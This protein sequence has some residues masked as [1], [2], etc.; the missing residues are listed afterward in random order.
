MEGET[1]QAALSSRQHPRLQI[2]ERDG[3]DLAV[4]FRDLDDAALLD[5]EQSPRSVT[6]IRQQYGIDEPRHR[7]QKPH[8]DPGEVRGTSPRARCEGA[9]G[10]SE[11]GGSRGADASEHE[12][13]DRRERHSKTMGDPIHRP[14][15]ALRAT[16]GGA[17]V[18]APAPAIRPDVLKPAPRHRPS[19]PMAAVAPCPVSAPCSSK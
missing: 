3:Q 2:E 11:W 18:G 10:F 6:G 15:S 17:S 1:E 14:G 4:A 16:Q 9:A 19:R 5:D 13:R 7:G 8:L 12:G